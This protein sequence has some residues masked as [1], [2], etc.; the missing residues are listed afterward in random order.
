MS[1]TTFGSHPLDAPAGRTIDDRVADTSAAVAHGRSAASW[2]AIFAGAVVAISATLILV[3]LGT[4]LGFAA[5]SPW[6]NR[7]VSP[8]AFT[9]SAAIWLIVTQWLSAALGGYVAGRLRTR[10]V[11]THTHE[12]FFRDTAHGLITWSVA[13][14]VVAFALT[15]SLGAALSGGARVA[16]DAAASGAASAPAA[17]AGGSPSPAL[18]YGMDRLFRPASGTSGPASG[19]PEALVDLDPRFEASHIIANALANG[20]KVPEADR[21]YLADLV[22]AHTGASGAEAQRRV[23]DFIA[24][25]VE[26]DNKARAA[27]DAARKS[28][29]ETAIF[30]ALAMLI[31]AFIASVSAALGGRLRDQHP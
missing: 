7:G 24:Q 22:A 23:D 12:V 9:V 19:G 8:A 10:W 21:A 18:L 20:G 15:S 1:S 30:T 25:A 2:P 17:L 11:G 29:A 5:I 14:V 3:A 4:G 6:H 31:G 13:T 27:A 28:A 26:A 16:A